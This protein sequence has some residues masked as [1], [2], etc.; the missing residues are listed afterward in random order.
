M[1]DH[2]EPEMAK[3]SA[4]ALAIGRVIAHSVM[5]DHGVDDK[6]TLTEEELAEVCAVAV[7]ETLQAV[8]ARRK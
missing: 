4:E 7:E 1:V 3:P 5:A 8:K 2:V 6:V